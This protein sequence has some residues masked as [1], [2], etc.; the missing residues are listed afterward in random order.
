LGHEWLGKWRRS[1]AQTPFG[2]PP[3][4]ESWR[5][6]VSDHPQFQ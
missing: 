4:E 5:A 1:D 3:G 2:A 6:A